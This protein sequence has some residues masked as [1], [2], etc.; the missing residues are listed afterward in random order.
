M[1]VE[2]FGHVRY[3]KPIKVIHDK[4]SQAV[5]VTGGLSLNAVHDPHEIGP[6]LCHVTATPIPEYRAGVRD[7]LLVL[8]GL[9]DGIRDVIP[10][11]L[12]IGLQPLHLPEHVLPVI[13]NAQVI[14]TGRIHGG[15]L[16]TLL[17]GQ[18]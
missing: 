11:I 9:P 2:P 18:L 10:L 7:G 17:G 6:G 4:L 13:G 8:D 3:A 12:S 5:G 15:L 16:V 1:P 14:K